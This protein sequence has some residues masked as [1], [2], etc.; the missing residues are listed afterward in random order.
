MRQMSFLMITSQSHAHNCNASHFSSG[1]RFV[2]DC[3]RSLPSTG[4]QSACHGL[5]KP[6]RE[7]NTTAKILP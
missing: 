6:P 7:T 4:R 2:R 3:N 1:H 5:D